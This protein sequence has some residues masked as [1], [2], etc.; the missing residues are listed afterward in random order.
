MKLTNAELLKELEMRFEQNNK[1]LEAQKKFVLDLEKVNDKLIASEILK[2]HF[3]SNI[4]NE[5][6]N[7]LT[8]ILGLSNMSISSKEGYEKNVG[9]LKLIYNETFLLNF[10]L[11]NIFFAAEIEAGK[12]YPEISKVNVKN[13]LKELIKSFESLYNNQRNRIILDYEGSEIF[14]TD[15]GKLNIVVSNLLSNAIKFSG[16]DSLVIVNANV[17][18]QTYLELSV[19]DLGIGIRDEN[20]SAIFDRFKQLDS[21]STKEFGGHGLGLSVVQS[22]V[23]MLNGEISIESKFGEGSRFSVK[24]PDGDQLNEK[25]ELFDETEEF[26]FSNSQNEIF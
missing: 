3:L 23:D 9:N 25:S 10:Q 5:I 15:H 26:L 20:I 8:S 2:S 18:E 19:Q 24:L 22:I 14:S 6:V 7:P 1:M 4:M 12:Y 21:G 17:E 16:E 11:R 13:L